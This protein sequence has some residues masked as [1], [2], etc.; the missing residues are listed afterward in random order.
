MIR[1]NDETTVD[2][3]PFSTLGSNSVL[4]LARAVIMVSL[5]FLRTSSVIDL[6]ADIT[7]WMI[8]Y[9][10]LLRISVICPI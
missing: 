5:S 2:K 1:R 3:S 9:G 7:L 6:Y 10:Q 8:T 4:K